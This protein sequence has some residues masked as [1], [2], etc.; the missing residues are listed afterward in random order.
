MRI[1]HPLKFG[2][3]YHW[4]RCVE[5]SIRHGFSQ[6]SSPTRSPSRHQSWFCQR[7]TELVHLCD[8]L[9]GHARDAYHFLILCTTPG[10]CM[11]GVKIFSSSLV[12]L[13]RVACSQGFCG[14]LC[15]TPPSRSSSANWTTPPTPRSEHARTTFGPFWTRFPGS[16]SPTISHSS[17]VKQRVYF[18]VP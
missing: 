2:A 16:P 3:E 11:P 4:H 5:Q 1:C 18:L 15:S 13:A 6:A 17:P 8:C 9:H 10:G 14:P 12:A 7:C